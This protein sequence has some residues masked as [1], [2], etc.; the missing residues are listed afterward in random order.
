MFTAKYLFTTPTTGTDKVRAL[1]IEKA[2]TPKEE[3]LFVLPALD[4]ETLMTM[5][6]QHMADNEWNFATGGDG[7][8]TFLLMMSSDELLWKEARKTLIYFS[9]AGE[10]SLLDIM[11]EVIEEDSPFTVEEYALSYWALDV[12]KV[13]SELKKAGLTNEEVLADAKLLEFFN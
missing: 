5:L 13:L 12:L 9:L 7:A 1:Q 4:K 6:T 10:K 11:P 3:A 2:V 8:A